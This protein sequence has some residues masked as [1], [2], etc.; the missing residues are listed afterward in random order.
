MYRLAATCRKDEI[1]FDPE[2]TEWDLVSYDQSEMNLQE[3]DENPGNPP[4]FRAGEEPGFSLV[5]IIKGLQM[6]AGCV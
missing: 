4:S 3:V 6:P 2:A 5:L 1:Y